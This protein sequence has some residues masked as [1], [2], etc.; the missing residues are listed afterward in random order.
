MGSWFSGQWFSFRCDALIDRLPVKQ[1]MFESLDLTSGEYHVA[2]LRFVDMSADDD[3][4]PIVGVES[5]KRTIFFGDEVLGKLGHIF[6]TT[7]SRCLPKIT[8]H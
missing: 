7:A 6:V 8:V 3:W 5:P 1:R 2:Y 4:Q